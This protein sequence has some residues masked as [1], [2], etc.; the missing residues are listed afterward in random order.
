MIQW[1][2]YGLGRQIWVE[3]LIWSFI[4]F[5]ILSKMFGLSDLNIFACKTSN[6]Y[7]IG[8]F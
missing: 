4:R 1:K 3:I 2:E 6:T 7:L 5:V 8:L